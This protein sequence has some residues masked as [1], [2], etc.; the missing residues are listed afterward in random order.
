[1]N[2]NLGLVKEE[3]VQSTELSGRYRPAMRH[4]D[5]LSRFV[6]HLLASRGPDQTDIEISNDR[7]RRFPSRSA[8][9]QVKSDGLGVGPTNAGKFAAALGYKS[10]LDLRIAAEAWA[11]SG[12]VAATEMPR[13]FDR[14]GHFA[15]GSRAA[16]LDG[17]LPEDVEAVRASSG[18]EREE[19]EHGRVYREILLVA[20]GRIASRKSTAELVRDEV[21]AVE[22]ALS[23]V[24]KRK[25]AIGP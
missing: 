10:E 22:R 13:K 2:W 4:G 20:G 23:G 24:V 19:W 8:I 6:R 17:A 3:N 14:A 18:W 15:A 9:S 21:N 5:P 7:D 12:P 11:S 1:M 25:R 16:L